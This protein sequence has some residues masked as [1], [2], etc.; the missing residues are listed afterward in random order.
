[1]EAKEF[2]GAVADGPLTLGLP[3]NTTILILIHCSLDYF[4]GQKLNLAADIDSC[5]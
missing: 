1:M 3:Q 4:A 2:I 5:Q